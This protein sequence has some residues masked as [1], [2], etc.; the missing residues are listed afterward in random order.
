[1]AQLAYTVVHPI[2]G[3]DRLGNQTGVG[4][5]QLGQL[6]KLHMTCAN[7]RAPA[8][9]RLMKRLAYAGPRFLRFDHFVER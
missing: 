5:G 1:M 8:P 3:H 2:G 9:V 4:F 6:V 7:A